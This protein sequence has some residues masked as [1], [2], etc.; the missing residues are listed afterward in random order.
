MTQTAAS[1][2]SPFL[3]LLRRLVSVEHREVRAL[4]L[5]FLYFFTLLASYYVLRPIR[6]EMGVQSGMR[7]LPWMFSAVFISML[8]LV[9]LFGWLAGRL[10][11]RRLIPTVYLFFASNLFGFYLALTTGLPRLMIAPVLFVWVSVFNLFV[12]Y[13]R[14]ARQLVPFF[15]LLTASVLVRA[16]D[17][18]PAAQRSGLAVVASAF[19]AV[20]SLVNVTQPLRQQFPRE[21]VRKV[22]ALAADAGASELTTVYAHHIYPVPEPFTMAPGARVLALAPHPLQYLPYQYEGFSR[23]QRQ[24]LRSTD[25]RMRAV[26][27]ARE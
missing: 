24:Q 10:P 5:S 3:S 20:Q 8:A 15:C 14:L 27:P 22:D 23:A 16:W 4:L 12:V 11:V 18:R 21:F 2:T 7:T 13:G 26:I 1:T 25:I 9:P 6:D 17:A 19:L